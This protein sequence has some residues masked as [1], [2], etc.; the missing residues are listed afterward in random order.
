M[1]DFKQ[2]NANDVLANTTGVSVEKVETDRTY[3]MVRGF[4]IVYRQS[5][6]ATCSNPDEQIVAQEY[7]CF[8]SCS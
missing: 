5:I 3:Y 1:D 2:V 4:D 7:L 8:W 6:C